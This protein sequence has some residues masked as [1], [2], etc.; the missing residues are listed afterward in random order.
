ADV[1]TNELAFHFEEANND[2]A[3]T[4][5][6]FDEE[7]RHVKEWTASV[8]QD[9]E[10]FNAE[11]PSMISRL[12]SERRSRLRQVASGA[13]S[14][15]IPIRSATTATPTPRPKEAPSRSVQPIDERYD[16]ALSFAG[17]DRAYVEEV[18]SVLK[19][20]GVKV[21]YDAYETANMWG[22]NLIEHL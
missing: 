15:G 8:T 21:F 5:R 1:R 18:A 3:A 4:K 14:L 2:V 22:K 20:K 19:S 12:V 16:V 10:R 9:V 17:E 6:Q 13:N 7:F 11:L